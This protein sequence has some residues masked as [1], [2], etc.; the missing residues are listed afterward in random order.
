MSTY[1]F[2]LSTEGGKTVYSIDTGSSKE[3]VTVMFSFSA[4]GTTCCPMIVYP[5]KRIP[6]KI[7]QSVPAE[8]GIA[9]SD[10][11]WMT[12]EIFYEYIAKVF[13][14]FL[15]SQGIILPVVLFVDGHKSHLAYQVSVLCN[16]LKIE[17]I[18]L[19]L[20]ATRIL[21][22]ADWLCFVRS[23]CTGGKL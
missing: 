7:S 6:E 13:H 5:Y 15:V 23:K 14:P 1:R 19:Y 22:P 9:R 11:G 10:R 8:W 12:S 20:N 17:V 18:A 21:Q 2:C 3:N 4:N 16:E